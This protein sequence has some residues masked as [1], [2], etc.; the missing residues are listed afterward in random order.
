MQPEVQLGG[1]CSKVCFSMLKKEVPFP[2]EPL[3]GVVSD[4]SDLPTQKQLVIMSTPITSYGTLIGGP[5]E[6]DNKC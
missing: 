1:Q 3:T 2:T 4:S 6:V 5:C